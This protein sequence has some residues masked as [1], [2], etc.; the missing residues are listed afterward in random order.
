MSSHDD[1][2][3]GH[4]VHNRLNENND[5]YPLT[6]ITPGI[7]RRVLD[8]VLRAFST[9]I[10]SQKTFL[11]EAESLAPY[12]YGGLAIR[13]LAW[14]GS[15]MMMGAIFLCYSLGDDAYK[16]IAGVLANSHH[17][18]AHDIYRKV[19]ATQILVTEISD[20][21]YALSLLAALM[22]WLYGLYTWKNYKKSARA[23][24]IGYVISFIVPFIVM[25]TFPFRKG[26]NVEVLAQDA[27]HSVINGRVPDVVNQILH[28]GNHATAHGAKK[29][30]KKQ[31]KAGIKAKLG[32]Y[33]AHIPKVNLTSMFHRLHVQI[34]DT[35]C[36]FSNPQWSAN[37]KQR[38]INAGFVRDQHTG[39]CPAAVKALKAMHIVPKNFNPSP[40]F[41]N[42]L[43]AT[44]DVNED[45]EVFSFNTEKKFTRAQC[46]PCESC[47]DP[48]CRAHSAHLLGKHFSLSPVIKHSFHAV[49]A[50]KKAFHA[51]EDK[52]KKQIKMEEEKI[53]GKIHKY[54]AKFEKQLTKAHPEFGKIIAEG[55]SAAKLVG[56]KGLLA[57]HKYEKKCK[58]EYAKLKAEQH[59]MLAK[60]HKEGQLKIHRARRH[61]KE[62]YKEAKH[63][64]TKRF[65]K[66]K[67][68][69]DK[70]TEISS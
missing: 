68:K 40:K 41:R 9:A 5:P 19:F 42:L 28:S 7:F 38:F 70:K 43:E 53:K 16:K 44:E 39:T 15:V 1:D 49:T 20:G 54:G 66:A 46:K 59:H 24:K 6:V 50:A 67:K 10:F 22:F 57:L 36:E 26:L 31:N 65:N 11:N 56:V 13:Y 23:L 33:A 58:S 61:G 4:D 63:H 21:V 34:P 45:E 48:E 12:G 27:C 29:A 14:R 30:A 2:A 62:K 35:I 60:L 55:K 3:V 69:M 37:I 51:F 47:V 52:H 17:H 8:T 18:S 32:M 25:L 64:F